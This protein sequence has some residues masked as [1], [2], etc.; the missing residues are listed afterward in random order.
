M[1]LA[2][3]QEKV[4]VMVDSSA[5]SFWMMVKNRGGT[6]SKGKKILTDSEFIKLKDK[7]VDQ[8]ID[9]INTN[10]SKIDWYCNFDYIKDSETI[11]K[12][13]LEL[14]KKGLKPAPVFH[15]DSSLDYFKRYCDL[16]HKLICIGGFPKARRGHIPRR[17]FFERLF[18][19]S[20]DYK[21]NLHGFAFTNIANL[22]EFP[23][24]SV[25][26]ATWAKTAAYG[27]ILVPDKDRS[28]MRS[29]HVSDRATKN[30][31][32]YDFMPR[33][34]KKEIEEFVEDKGFDFGKVRSSIYERCIFNAYIYSH[35]DKLIDLENRKADW[36]PYL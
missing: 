14:E 23:W 22:L 3:L 25:D 31:I 6:V 21:V 26:S 35:L 1:Y 19:I 24:W 15:G 33:E 16:G 29:I 30:K 34:I 2:C 11:W 17:K 27:M 12:M 10:E 28:V 9:F 4:K 13:Q 36:E 8:Y 20:E 5:F 7:V 32:S 18:R